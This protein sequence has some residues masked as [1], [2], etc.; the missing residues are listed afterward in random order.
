MRGEKEVGEAGYS[1]TGREVLAQPTVSRS[2]VRKKAERLLELKSD[3]RDV[4]MFGLKSAREQCPSRI[5]YRSI[6]DVFSTRP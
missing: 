4:L 1:P 5:R 3:R 6:E 2:F